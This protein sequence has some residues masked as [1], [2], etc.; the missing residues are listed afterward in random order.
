MGN[1]GQLWT[2]DAITQAIEGQWLAP[3]ESDL[4]IK[5]VTYYV[6]HIEPGDLIFA[7][8]QKS[9]GTKYVN[10]ADRL[11]EMQNKGAVMAI[12]DSIPNTIPPGLAV[13]FCPNTYNAL[14]QLGTAA[15]TRFKGKVIC[16]TGSVGK[17]STKRG[18][19]LM[20]GK[21]GRTGESRK[22]FNHS[23]GVALS[24][25]QT[26]SDC[27]Y[28]VF[29]FGVDAPQHTLI[30]AMMARPHVALVT[31]IQHDH[32]HYYPT[33]EALVDQKSLLFRG[34]T[35][36]NAVVL[37]RDTPYFFRLKTAALSNNAK[38]IIT[39]GAH[40]LADIR[41]LEY[42]CNVDTSQVKASVFGD[43]IHYELTIPG[44]H[45]VRNSLA[46]L[47]GVCA[48]NANYKQAAADLITMASLPDH[49]LRSTIPYQSGEF[50]LIND[51]VSANPASVRAAFDYLKLF[52]LSP[53]SRKILVLGDMDQLGATS[54]AH[55][56]ALVDP[57]LRS[58]ID[59]LFGIGPDVK[60]LCDSV[61]INRLGL[62]TQDTDKLIEHLMNTIIPG[63]I[64]MVKGSLV[65]KDIIARIVKTVEA[66]SQP[67]HV[68][69]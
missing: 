4:N 59:L 55:H 64:V 34:L 66:L 33:L 60:N 13:Y 58:D 18:I 32:H 39:F 57:F 20:L 11:E 45:N 48:V 67:E 29:E 30:K 1:H 35:A 7:L 9:W 50:Q 65:Q 28:G 43:I 62:H 42:Q 46:M 47:A 51:T 22:N 41:L 52:E 69:C 27:A 54:T 40:R 68:S 53:G 61:P 19:A 2:T 37:N 8:S 24:L 23:P 12:V 44:N 3:P 26:P 25:A 16:V 5:G 56:T 49:C 38:Q 6:G 10:T 21:Q 14:I 31:E 15:R 63:D 36:D 17:S